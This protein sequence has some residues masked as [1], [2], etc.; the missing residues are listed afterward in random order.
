MMVN[1]LNGTKLM[2]SYPVKFGIRTIE[3]NGARFLLNGED[4]YFTGFG[5]I[6]Q[7]CSTLSALRL[8]Y[9]R[10]GNHSL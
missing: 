3:V 4:F 9:I 6:R 7:M 10:S 8:M 5:M 2:D 1:V